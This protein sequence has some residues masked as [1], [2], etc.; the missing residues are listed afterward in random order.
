MPW[1]GTHDEHSAAMAIIPYDGSVKMRWIA[2]YNNADVFA[3][4]HFRRS[5]FARIVS[6]IPLWDLDEI[7][8]ETTVQYQILPGGNHVTMA[9]HYREIAKRSGL[10]VSLEAKATG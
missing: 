8:P 5:P 2:N 7:S 6:L 3:K 9:K 10:W 1:F 4:N